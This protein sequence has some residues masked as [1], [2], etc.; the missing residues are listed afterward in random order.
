[1]RRP[2]AGERGTALI[3]ALIMLAVMGLF[4]FGFQTINNNDL[5]FAAYSRAETLA[6]GR[7]EAGVEDGI[8][9]IKLGLTLPAPGTTCFVNAMAS[10]ATCGSST[11][12]PNPNTV[13]FQ[14]A[15]ASADTSADVIFPVLSVATVNGATRSVRVL[16]QALLAG[17]FRDSDVIFGPQITF[18]GD[19]SPT[20]GDTYSATTLKFQTYGKS[21]QPATG[22]TATNLVSPQ[23]MAGED[24]NT[25][26]AG[27]GDFLTE[28]TSGS[29]SEVAP[30][31]CARGSNPVNWHPASPIAMS[32]ADF[33]TV[34]LK[35][36]GNNANL[37]SGVSV[38]QA[39]QNS[40]NVTYSP[41]SYTPPYWSSVSGANSKVYLIVS[42]TGTLCVNSSTGAVNASGCGGTTYGGGT[43][44][45]RYIDWGL[46][47]DDLN[48]ATS[49]TF[50][51]P[52][53]CSTCNGGGPNG[54][55]NGIRYIPLPP[56][57]NPLALACQI[58]E[59]SPWVTA[60]YNTTTDGLSCS[61]PVQAGSG[62]I[63]GTKSAPEFLVIDNGPPGG[64][65]VTLSSSGSA[66]GCSDT[67]ASAQ[68]GMIFATGDLNLQ[69]FT[70]SGFIFT[71]GNVYSHGH[72]LVQGGIFSSAGQSHIVD[73]L[74]TM[75]FCG[76]VSV[77]PMPL[78]PTFFTFTQVSW[79]DRPSNQP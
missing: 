26:G 78:S 12:S 10:G 76:G 34:M 33:N 61:S 25:Q 8:E 41:L 9:R 60:F 42:N 37:P 45:M 19:T 14:P 77:V 59:P 16:I 35:W 27:P 63:T 43:S 58:A 68:W 3:T 28:C 71:N 48:R 66:T 52:P 22:A 5:L 31:N 47:S 40:A 44:M 30:T 11:T 72:N 56:A 50:Y 15:L 29:S 62:T 75:Q 7:A 6:L 53:S 1:M 46:V 23:V 54:Y 51:Q 55:Q 38:V 4:L 67:F 73:T 20:T 70:F 57:V 2:T 24:I 49:S 69:N 21:P 13:V 64:T 65:Q 39:T 79:Q 74:G 17:G 18:Q 32:A 36:N